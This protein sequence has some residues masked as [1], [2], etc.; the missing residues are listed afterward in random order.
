MLE[1]R[2]LA[3]TH[4]ELVARDGEQVCAKCGGP[5]ELIACLDA[6]EERLLG[7]VVGLSGELVL[8][9]PIDLVEVARAQLLAGTAIAVAPSLQ[10]GEVVHRVQGIPA[11]RAAIAIVASAARRGTA[12]ASSRSEV[13][14]ADLEVDLGR[15]ALD[16]V[17]EVEAEEREH[18]VVEIDP[19]A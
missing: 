4:V 1:L 9:E 16:A 12:A 15:V 17:A 11:G 7:Q 5:T 8:E 13:G 14:Q 3:Q 18:D 10:Q 2:D 19:E 6:G